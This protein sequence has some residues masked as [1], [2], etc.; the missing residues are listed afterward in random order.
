MSMESNRPLKLEEII[1]LLGILA[2]VS[3][4]DAGKSLAVSG[5]QHNRQC[6][7]LILTVPLA[8]CHQARASSQAQASFLSFSGNKECRRLEAQPFLV[9]SVA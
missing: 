5:K 3:C 2:A 8:L 9:S 1:V 4:P 6:K 7:D